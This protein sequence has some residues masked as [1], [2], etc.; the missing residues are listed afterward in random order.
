LSKQNLIFGLS[1]LQ[2]LDLQFSILLLSNYISIPL[3]VWCGFEVFSKLIIEM[4]IWKGSE[5]WSKAEKKTE[6][7]IR[8]E[9]WFGL[10]KIDFLMWISHIG[11]YKLS[12]RKGLGYR[13]RLNVPNQVMLNM[14]FLPSC[15]ARALRGNLS[16]LFPVKLIFVRLDKSEKVLAPTSE[17]KLRSA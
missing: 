14:K 16:S 6:A 15:K 7:K 8:K 1:Q 4:E 11:S 2:L 12:G 17:I 5:R 13:R 10:T 3:L 9:I